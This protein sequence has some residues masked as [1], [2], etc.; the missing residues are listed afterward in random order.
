MKERAKWLQKK[1]QSQKDKKKARKE[2]LEERAAKCRREDEAARANP[3]PAKAAGAAGA[4]EPSSS[5]SRAPAS[6]PEST[7]TWPVPADWYK[8][9]VPRGWTVD[10]E[11][12]N[13]MPYPRA[14]E[15]GT[16]MKILKRVIRIKTNSFRA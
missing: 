2:A 16:S 15:A 10:D 6:V 12:I 11:I 3:A 14:G 1:I 7:F 9:E 4:S 5:S 13:R 8:P